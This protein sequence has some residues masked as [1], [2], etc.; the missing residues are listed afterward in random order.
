MLSD[1]EALAALRFRH[2]SCHFF[3]LGQV[4]ISVSKVLHFVYSLWQLNAQ[5]NV[6]TDQKWSECKC[7]CGASLNV[8]YTFNLK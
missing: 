3:K 7:Y 8:F 4:N 1:C 5:V 6:C 2:L